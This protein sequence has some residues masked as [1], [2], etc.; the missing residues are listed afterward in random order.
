MSGNLECGPRMRHTLVRGP[1]VV[2][3]VACGKSDREPKLLSP[4][5]NRGSY[6]VCGAGGVQVAGALPGW[7]AAAVPAEG[8]DGGQPPGYGA[9][10]QRND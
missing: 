5:V 1:K 4:A 10:R 7:D 9:M 6:C 2:H 8:L 3:A